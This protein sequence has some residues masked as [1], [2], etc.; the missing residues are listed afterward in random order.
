[1]TGWQ[2][3]ANPSLTETPTACG[4]ASRGMA[5][6]HVLALAVV[7]LRKRFTPARAIGRRLPLAG[8]GRGLSTDQHAN[9]GA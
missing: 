5:R 7:N 6:K 1:M 3:V 9:T 8:S 2:A 4:L